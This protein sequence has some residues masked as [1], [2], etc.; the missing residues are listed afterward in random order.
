MPSKLS[1]DTVG[2]KL[3][4]FFTPVLYEV[5]GT[6]RNSSYNDIKNAYNLSDKE[7][8]FHALKYVLS[9]KATDLAIE[10]AIA[11]FLP[12]SNMKMSLGKM[13]GFISGIFAENGIKISSEKIKNY[14]IKFIGVKIGKKLTEETLISS[15][16]IITGTFEEGE[17][18]KIQI[19]NYQKER[20]YPAVAAREAERHQ[21]AENFA[22]KDEDFLRPITTKNLNA[23]SP[24]DTKNMCKGDN[25]CI[26]EDKF[27]KKYPNGDIKIARERLSRF[28]NFMDNYTNPD[29]I[30]RTNYYLKPFTKTE[31][32]YSNKQKTPQN[33]GRSR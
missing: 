31:R 20:L 2:K 17:K 25:I 6:F 23:I 29:W 4:D 10:A 30:A 7:I 1:N 14:I 26:D 27:R 21:V 22:G 5:R 33:N 18:I 8:K 9:I 28:L 24:E 16:N 3:V 12:T 11:Y 13:S 19:D 32:P 15:N